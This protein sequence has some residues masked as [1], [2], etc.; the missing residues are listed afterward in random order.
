MI[1][2]L[3]LSA[4]QKALLEMDQA[5]RAAY[6]A[7]KAALL[8][9]K[10]NVWQN[11]AATPQQMVAAMGTRAATIFAASAAS[12]QVI[13]LADGV[14]FKVMPDGWGFQANPDGTVTLIPPT[15]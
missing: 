8:K 14:E 1:E 9:G 10:R 4:E 11:P 15:A 3:N 7:V 5:N 13:S 6:A 2:T 12:A